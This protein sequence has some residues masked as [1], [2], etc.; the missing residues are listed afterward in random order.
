MSRKLTATFEGHTFTRKTDRTYTH[1]LIGRSFDG[2]P[3]D[4]WEALSWAGSLALANKKQA[5]NEFRRYAE[6][7]IIPVNQGV[8]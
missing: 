8:I 1:V 3:G 7:K 6:L 4:P 5:S 2:I